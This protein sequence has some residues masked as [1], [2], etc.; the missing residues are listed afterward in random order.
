LTTSDAREGDDGADAIAPR[1][2]AVASKQSG[3]KR[4]RVPTANIEREMFA[5]AHARWR[6]FA[7]EIAV[8]DASVTSWRTAYTDSSA[9]V[10]ILPGV[11]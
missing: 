4:S 2:R 8:D 5:V 10:P 6:Y 3:R 11:T 7:K 9:T 1:F